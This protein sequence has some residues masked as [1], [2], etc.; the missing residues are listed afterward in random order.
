[1]PCHWLPQLL[2]LMLLLLFNC[3]LPL[4]PGNAQTTPDDRA[5]TNTNPLP[6]M[7]LQPRRPPHTATDLNFPTG[8][9]GRPNPIAQAIGQAFMSNN[10]NEAARLLRQYTGDVDELRIFG[11]DP[12]IVHVA[13]QGNLGMLDLLLERK[14]DPNQVDT[15]G[16]TALFA[17]IQRTAWPIALRLI[18]AGADV[19]KVNTNSPTHG[20]PLGELVNMWWNGRPDHEL[21][22][23][24]LEQLLV[25]GADPFAPANHLY[26]PFNQGRPSS[27]LESAMMRNDWALTDLLLTNRPSPARRTPAGDTALHLAVQWGRTNAVDFLLSAGFFINQTNNDGLAPL[28]CVV[29]SSS[30][31]GSNPGQT[32]GI[33]KTG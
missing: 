33:T 7:P 15:S 32:F 30:G 18:A 25:H 29:G 28:Q 22:T 5:R 17:A 10:T 11:R 19:T 6:H 16:N 1:M 4:Q 26:S 14:A 27:V 12:L 13:R 3:L 9:I 20:S 8:A 23:Q 21:Q 31:S 2:C 24:L